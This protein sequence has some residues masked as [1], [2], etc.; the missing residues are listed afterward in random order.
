MGGD[1]RQNP[2]CHGACCCAYTPCII[3][4]RH[5]CS[6]VMYKQTFKVVLCSSFV[7]C[8][9]R[10]KASRAACHWWYDHSMK[11]PGGSAVALRGNPHSNAV[12]S[13]LCGVAAAIHTTNGGIDQR[14]GA[15]PARPRRPTLL[16]RQAARR[17]ARQGASTCTPIAAAAWACHCARSCAGAARVD[18]GFGVADLLNPWASTGGA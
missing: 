18:G 11:P 17:T 6:T 4:F 7:Q 16:P 10:G 12:S 14:T 1:D 15:H 8:M 3:G 13:A 5:S 9:V 2:R